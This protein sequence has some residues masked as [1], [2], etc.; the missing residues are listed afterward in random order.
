MR[1]I[2]GLLSSLIALALAL[3]L[4]SCAADYAD[5]MDC[6]EIGRSLADRLD[7]GQEYTE[8]ESTHREYYFDDT[9]HYDDCSLLYSRDVNDVSEIGVFHAPDAG[10]A[11]ELAEDCREYLDDLRTSTRAFV[12]SYAPE[13]LPK[14]DN[15]EVRRFGNYVAYA[16]LPTDK[17]E[18]FFNSLEE[19]LRG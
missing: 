13:E 16:I 9:E 19:M 7:D 10:S 15:A 11:Q 14:L 17:T 6:S 5:D 4:Y 18:D 1:K 8:F 12:E 3:G 2:Y